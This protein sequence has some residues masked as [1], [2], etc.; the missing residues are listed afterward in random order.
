[1]TL[2]EGLLGTIKGGLMQQYGPFHWLIV[3]AIIA[4][5]FHGNEIIE[6]V[7]RLIDVFHGRGS[8]GFSK[9]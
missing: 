7:D 8:R 3:L 5:L 4:I 1:V 6:F 9:L 2:A